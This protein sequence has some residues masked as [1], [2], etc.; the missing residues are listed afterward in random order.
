[1]EKRK[2]AYGLAKKHQHVDQTYRGEISE[3]DSDRDQWRKY[4]HGVSSLQK[5]DS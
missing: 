2:T 3:N 4:V 1:M 5:E